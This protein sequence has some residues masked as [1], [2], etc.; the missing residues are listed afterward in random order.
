MNLIIRGSVVRAKAVIFF[1]AACTG[2]VFGGCQGSNGENG[3]QAPPKSPGGDDCSGICDATTPCS[4]SCSSG[5]VTKSCRSI[6]GR[7]YA[8]VSSTEASAFCASAADECV[9]T[10]ACGG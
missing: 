1:V 4:A 5:G 2:A 7:P 8:W 6:N 3:L 9:S 10:F